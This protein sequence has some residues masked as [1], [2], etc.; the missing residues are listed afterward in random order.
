MRGDFY[1]P[2]IPTL[3]SR[4]RLDYDFRLELDFC[5]EYAGISHQEFLSW[6]ELER[7]KAVMWMMERHLKCP[8][9]GTRLEEWD[10][11]GGGNRHAYIPQIYTCP[12]C[13]ISGDALT[14]AQKRANATGGGHGLRV[15]LL[16]K[17]VV[18]KQV[19]ERTPEQRQRMAEM[20]RQRLAQEKVG[21]VEVEPR[22]ASSLGSSHRPPP[23]DSK[24]RSLSTSPDAEPDAE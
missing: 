24:N 11:K 10:P 22:K 4:Y 7:N 8:H 23:I 6:P 1:R 18:D 19:R 16:P 20:E 3:A 21:D 2:K 17:Y 5:F 14:A 13:E 15:R 12:G 9:C